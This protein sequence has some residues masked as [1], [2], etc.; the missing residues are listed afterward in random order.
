MPE[1]I[2]LRGLIEYKDANGDVYNP[3]DAITDFSTSYETVF[4]VYEIYIG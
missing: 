4:S 3:G 1:W 2:S